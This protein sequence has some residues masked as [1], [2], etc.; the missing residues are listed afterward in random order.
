LASDFACRK[1]V[2]LAY[3]RLRREEQADETGPEEREETD[4]NDKQKE[5]A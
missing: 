5:E 1:E 2:E 3:V 4:G